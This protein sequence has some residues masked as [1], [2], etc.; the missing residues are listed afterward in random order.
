MHASS[1][2]LTIT[3]FEFENAALECLH[4]TYQKLLPCLLAVNLHS[5][6]PQYVNGVV[7]SA[8]PL[9]WNVFL[10]LLH[11][12]CLHWRYPDLNRTISL[13][14]GDDPG[15]GTQHKVSQFLNL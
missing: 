4:S 11:L 12:C 6:L 5:A 3:Y 9:F 8:F 13:T 15:M 2:V 1:E 7:G 14:L 10:F